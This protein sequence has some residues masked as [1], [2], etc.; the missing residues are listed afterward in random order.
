MDDDP[1]N[2]TRDEVFYDDGAKAIWLTCLIGLPFFTGD[3][4]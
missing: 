3:L 2:L 4:W 1:E